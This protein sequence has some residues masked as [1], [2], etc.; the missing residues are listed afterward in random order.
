[1]GSRLNG[2]QSEQIRMGAR[3]VQLQL[4]AILLVYQQPIRL[5]V[6]F[7]ISRVIAAQVMVPVL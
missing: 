6:A 3:S 7:P 5:Y 2:L 1:M 4:I